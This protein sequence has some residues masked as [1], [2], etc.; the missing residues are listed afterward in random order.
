MSLTAAKTRIL[1]TGAL[2]LVMF[3]ACDQ[4]SAK[5]KDSRYARVTVGSVEIKDWHHDIVK[6]YPN[7]SHYHWNPM[8]ANVQGWN[9]VRP[10]K[11]G[12]KGTMPQAKR[13]ASR[14]NSKR[15]ARVVKKTAE[16]RYKKYSKY[17]PER[18][19]PKFIYKKPIHVA[20]GSFS[21]SQKQLN[22]KLNIKPVH[23]SARE[24]AIRLKKEQIAGRVLPK[25]GAPREHS[26]QDKNLHGELR[27][28]TTRAKLAQAK[29][30]EKLTAARLD[31]GRVTGTLVNKST[32]ASL[33]TTG[34]A[35]ALNAA[36]TRGS[37]LRRA[38]ARENSDQ[39]P[40]Q[41]TPPRIKKY[42]AYDRTSSRSHRGFSHNDSSASDAED[43]DS[44]FFGSGF[45]SG[46]KN[47]AVKSV[48]G[49]LNF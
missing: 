48:R 11:H 2:F 6:S 44:Q 19:R 22:G 33:A 32:R 3:S 42:K 47:R 37:L 23:V 28:P 46:S 24:T 14:Q 29:V 8:Y 10:P 5:S 9:K 17:N 27:L 15:R 13:S 30:G 41:T 40:S 16:R 34:T 43:G 38:S 4:V 20:T 26:N 25:H 12:I 21:Q 45:G 35:I 31:S 18:S 39:D 49:R 36:N 7:L 1:L